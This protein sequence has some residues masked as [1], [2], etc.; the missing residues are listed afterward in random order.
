MQN[1]RMLTVGVNS[2]DYQI[3]LVG[4]NVNCDQTSMPNFAVNSLPSEIQ[5]VDYET[6]A[7]SFQTSLLLMCGGI[8]VNKFIQTLNMNKN[9]HYCHV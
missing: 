1:Y 4:E 8:Y 7:F 9:C 5:L 6:I 2:L 3:T